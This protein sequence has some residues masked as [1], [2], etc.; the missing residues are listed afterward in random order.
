MLIK[1]AFFELARGSSARFTENLKISVIKEAYKASE[2]GM[3]GT[4]PADFAKHK[5]SRGVVP[6][7]VHC[8]IL[9]RLIVFTTCWI[10]DPLNSVQFKP[11]PGP[12]HHDE[13]HIWIRHVLGAPTELIRS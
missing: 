5:R 13:P 1:T 4:M 11:R 12:P 9:I 3:M 6:G 8:H 2:N 10:K 7:T